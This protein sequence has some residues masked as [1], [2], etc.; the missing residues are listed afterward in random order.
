M[1]CDIKNGMVTVKNAGSIP[2]ERIL[3]P[4]INAAI[5]GKR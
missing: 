4:A 3:P 5:I 1:V 2:D